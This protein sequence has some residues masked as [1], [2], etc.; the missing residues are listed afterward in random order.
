MDAEKAEQIVAVA[1]T[2]LD[3]PYTKDFRCMDF[4]REVYRRVGLTLPPIERN[5]TVDDLKNPPVGFV[6]Y[7]LHKEN[8][9]DRK[10]SHVAII[11]PGRTCIHM[12]YYFGGRV[13][14]TDLDTFLEIYHLASP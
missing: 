9:F 10:Y 3:R 5:L 12:S 8:T 1:R 2:F 11:L 14:I 13:V 4:V 7:L 6:L